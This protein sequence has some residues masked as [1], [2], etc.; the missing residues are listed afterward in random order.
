MNASENPMDHQIE[1][2]LDVITEA[3]LAEQYDIDHIVRE[4]D[5]PESRVNG[6]VDL[7][8]DLR[9]LL[10]TQPVSDDFV[11][12]L[13]EDLIGKKDGVFDR[14][15]YLPGRV[16]IAAGLTLVA[17]FMLISRRR[18]V[19]SSADGGDLGVLQGAFQSSGG[20]VD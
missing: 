20:D 15:R 4:Y 17:G 3:L 1:T 7:I 10:F 14:L 12:R 6:L 9:D 13:K 19:D 5:V 18:F 11:K 2:L 8:H 16:Q